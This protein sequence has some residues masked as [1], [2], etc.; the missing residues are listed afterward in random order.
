MNTLEAVVRALAGSSS[1]TPL[2][3][4]ADFCNSDSRRSI[5]GGRHP[6]IWLPR[7]ALCKRDKSWP[8]LKS[9]PRVRCGRGT[10][11]RFAWHSADM[12][13][14]Q[15]ALSKSAW[16]AEVNKMIDVYKAPV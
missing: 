8:A 3:I 10:N 4:V 16:T 7:S 1:K 13:L 5:G 12:V 11:N 14:N 15:L 6:A 9:S 2:E